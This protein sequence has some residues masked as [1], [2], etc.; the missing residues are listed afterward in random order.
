MAYA[1]ITHQWPDESATVMEVGVDANGPDAL[2]EC[3]R[4][5]T[6]L[7]Q[8]CTDNGTAAEDDL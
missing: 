3:V 2:D 1:K 6:D 5:V 7:W 4:R 8:V